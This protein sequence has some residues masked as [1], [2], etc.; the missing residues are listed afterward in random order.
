MKR[1]TSLLVLLLGVSFVA[2]GDDTSTT[3]PCASC[4]CDPSFCAPSLTTKESALVNIEYA[5]N[6]R[7]ASA[8]HALLDDNFIFYLAPADAGNGVPETWDRAEEITVNNHLFDKNYSILPCQSIFM[9]LKNEQG[10]AWSEVIPSSAPD[11]V[12]YSTVLYYDFKFDIW[13]NIYVPDTGSKAEFTVRNAGTAEAPKWK[14][15]AMRDLG[16]S[17]LVSGTS[18]AATEPTTWGKVKV[19]YR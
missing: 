11:E 7:N 1:I 12:W 16:G 18:A 6:K 15:V 9:D 4:K 10:M 2:C 3:A 14:L 8:Y 19:M 17:S 5:Y 13:P